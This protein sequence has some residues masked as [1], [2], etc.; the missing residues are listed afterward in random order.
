MSDGISLLPEEQR[1]K[2]DLM[3][4]AA[5]AKPQ[6]AKE[7]SFSIPKEE[8]DDIEIIE[9]DEG[10]IEQVLESEPPL[11]RFIYKATSFFDELREKMFQPQESEPPPK[12]P[13]QFFTP[14]KPAAKP[15]TPSAP[16]AAPAPVPSGAQAAV[17]VPAGAKPQPLSAS[18]KTKAVV[19][20]FKATPRRVRVIK[21]VRKPIH[22]SFVSEN[23]LQLMRVDIPR[24]QF[25]LV[26]LVVLLGIL[27][28]GS[29][30]A[31]NNQSTSAKSELAKA[32]AQLTSV[33]G[34]IQ[35][36]LGDWKTFQNLE[37]KLRALSGLLDAH[38]SPMQL[39][40][41]IEQATLPTVTYQSFSL[42]PDK[43]VTLSVTS[44]GFETA[45]AQVAL[46]QRSDFVK[47]VEA[48]GYTASYDPPDAPRPKSVEFQM[49][50]TLNDEILLVSPPVAAAN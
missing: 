26:G 6:A 21:R 41:R 3:K 49:I 10:E 40:E 22:V 2:E 28:G 18:L 46:F 33:R 45:A 23:D 39:L 12:L 47:K 35:S 30:Y 43:R 37:P 15:V 25:T 24:R 9:I 44:D 1:K 13:P 19:K 8:G 27:V 20:P 36:K 38:L 16:G 50:V 31:L 11:T 5:A 48:T 17:A 34:E 29:A 14:P 4:S 32:D 7:L 42:S